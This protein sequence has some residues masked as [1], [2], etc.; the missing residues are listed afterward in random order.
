MVTKH[1]FGKGQGIYLSSFTVNPENTR[2]LSKLLV[3]N[4]DYDTMPFVTDKVEA[5]CTYFPASQKTI[6]MNNSEI[7]VTVKWKNLEG[8]EETARLTPHETCIR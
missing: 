1:D 7:E 3:R 6:I 5:E 4:T 2:L 8:E